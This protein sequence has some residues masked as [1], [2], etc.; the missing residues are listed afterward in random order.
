MSLP[1]VILTDRGGADFRDPSEAVIEDAI[2][3]LR[4][5]QEDREHCSIILRRGIDGGEMRV[6][7]LFAGGGVTYSHYSDCDFDQLLAEYRDDSLG[8]LDIVRRFR[9][10]RSG[11]IEALE[12]CTWTKT[13]SRN[14]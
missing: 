3:D 6:L 8:V 5:H 7:E 11:D 9:Y 14:G 4:S 1:W 10:L 13:N 2:A 12:L